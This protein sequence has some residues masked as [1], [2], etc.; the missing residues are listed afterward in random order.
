MIVLARTDFVGRFEVTFPSINNRGQVVEDTLASFEREELV[1]LFGVDRFV[2]FEANPIDPIY[3]DLYT[4]L[5][6]GKNYS[7]GLKSVLL[8]LV[9]L[10]YQRENYVMSTENGRVKKDSSTST[11][12]YPYTRDIQM[13]NKAVE[14]WRS[15]QTFCSS[16][17]DDFKGVD[18]KIQFY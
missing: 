15:M 8:S 18:K 6:N 2:L 12:H 4:P 5:L 7:E 1:K 14:G 11:T 17:F 9:Y 3:D 13:Y 16:A 10:R